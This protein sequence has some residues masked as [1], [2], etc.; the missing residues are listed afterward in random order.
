[1]PT[2]SN[3]TQY[4]GADTDAST[5]CDQ[6]GTQ[7]FTALAVSGQQLAFWLCDTHAPLP[8]TATD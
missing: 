6:E 3:G 2:C 1:M 8:D 7:A 5:P 4:F